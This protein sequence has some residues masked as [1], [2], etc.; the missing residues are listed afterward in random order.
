MYSEDPWRYGYSADDGCASGF[1]LGKTPITKAEVDAVQRFLQENNVLPEN[2]RLQKIMS[3]GQ[4]GHEAGASYT[5][6]IASAE[7]GW[8]P[9]L[10]TPPHLSLLPDSPDISIRTGD[11]S[12]VLGKIVDE[13]ELAAGQAANFR[14]GAM[15][16]ALVRC[17]RTG[18]HEHFR[19]AQKQWVLDR[20][21]AVELIIGF[22]E[23][24][25]DPSG[26]RG[27]WEGIV[28]ITNRD[29]SKKFAE[30]VERSS[31]FIS[32][33]PWNGESV[34]LEPGALSDFEPQRFSKPDFNS[35]DSKCAPAM[36]TPA[37]W[38]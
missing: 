19:E 36:T 20:S 1:Y 22:I 5:L 35:L 13:L 2:T 28:A 9:A 10:K 33:L 3:A 14:Q 23:T 38:R 27:S 24:Y 16:D 12:H 11:Y 37:L 4:A 21:P 32:L 7:E 18:D 29:R 8:L 25:Q 31:E 26:V 30:L 17:F 34:G 6:S 15:I